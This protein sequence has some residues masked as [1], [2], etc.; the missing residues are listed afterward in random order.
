MSMYVYFQTLCLWYHKQ[1]LM[2]S[3]M[4]VC[5]F[6]MNRSS[7]RPGFLKR[8]HQF[9]GSSLQEPVPAQLADAGAL[10]HRT[11]GRDDGDLA[12][13]KADLR[14]S[15]TLLNPLEIPT[16]KCGTLEMTFQ[17]HPK[18]EIQGRDG[19][20]GFKEHTG[21]WLAQTRFPSITSKTLQMILGKWAHHINPWAWR[22]LQ[23]KGP[24]GV[25]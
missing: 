18:W 9:S 4:P 8:T 17:N 11:R 21:K 5:L 1:L 10:V 15:T 2:I 22:H 13:I 12:I 7:T 20:G 6:K 24:K 19:Q 25:R 23:N 16:L 14:R 3:S